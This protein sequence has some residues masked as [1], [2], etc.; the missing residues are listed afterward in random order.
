MRANMALLLRLL[1][2][3]ERIAAKDGAASHAL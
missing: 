1:M 2:M 3:R